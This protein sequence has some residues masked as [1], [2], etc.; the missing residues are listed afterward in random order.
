MSENPINAGELTLT[1]IE[2]NW[3]MDDPLLSFD[4]LTDL[5]TVSRESI[6][7]FKSRRFK[8]RN[9][10]A[11]SISKSVLSDVP[12]DDLCSNLREIDIG[13]Q[14]MPAST[15]LGLVWDVEND[16]L[17]VSCKRKLNGI[18]T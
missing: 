6:A 13:T 18:T 17:R 9:W 11:N 3:C 8:L 5:Q 16:R 1:A 4:S 2:N 15:A 12:K 14:L 10:V 7:L